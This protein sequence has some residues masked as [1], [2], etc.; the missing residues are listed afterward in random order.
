[1]RDKDF[2]FLRLTILIVVCVPAIMLSGI[3]TIAL[4]HWLFGGI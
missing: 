4:A 1:M 2:E 3:G